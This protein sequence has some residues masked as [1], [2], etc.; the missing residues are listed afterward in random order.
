MIG[1]QAYF[2]LWN[3]DERAWTRIVVGNVISADDGTTCLLTDQGIMFVPTE[4]EF[5]PKAGN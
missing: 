2:R 5:E 1:R 4:A 3:P